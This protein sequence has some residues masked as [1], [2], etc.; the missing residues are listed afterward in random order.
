MTF[1]SRLF[2]L[3]VLVAALAGA[4]AWGYAQ[5]VDSAQGLGPRVL[6]GSDIGFELVGQRKGK[7]V[8]RLV[9][10]IDGK[11]QEVQFEPVVTPLK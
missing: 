2:V 5:G 6:S 7:P 4:A 3:A 10:R 11:W 9:V 1:V 8:G